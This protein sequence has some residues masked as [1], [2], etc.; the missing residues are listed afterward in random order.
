MKLL[1]P[2]ALLALCAGPTQA[3]KLSPVEAALQKI[4][5]ATW[6]E[7]VTTLASDEFEG[8]APGTHGETVT[9]DYLLQQFKR[10]GLEPG[11]PEL[12]ERRSG[13][14]RRWQSSA[15]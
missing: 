5:G 13:R 11:N 14:S 2:M 4:D 15:G 1:L 10:M 6:L 8:R 7:H 3:A 9:V 12:V